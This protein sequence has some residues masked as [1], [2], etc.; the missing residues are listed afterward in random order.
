MMQELRVRKPPL[1]G[2]G[3]RVAYYPGCSL[4]GASRAY[5][6]SARLVT[7]ELGLELDYIED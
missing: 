7:K 2:I 5:D 6:V 3:K 1:G 4:E